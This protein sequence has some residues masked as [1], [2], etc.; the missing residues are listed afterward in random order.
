MTFTQIL[1]QY[2][3]IIVPILLFVVVNL[4]LCL[5]YTLNFITGMG[6]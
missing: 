3:I 5:C 2:I 1:F 4:L 6:F